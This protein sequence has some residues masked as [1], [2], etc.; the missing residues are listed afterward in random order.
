VLRPVSSVKV[1]FG[2]YRRGPPRSILRAMTNESAAPTM[3]LLT[4]EQVG[5]RLDLTP[6]SVDGLVKSGEL[7]PVRVSS[8]NDRRFWPDEIMAYALHA[9]MSEDGRQSA[10]QVVSEPDR[11][12]DT[13]VVNPTV[14]RPGRQPSWPPFTGPIEHRVPAYIAFAR[15]QDLV[16]YLRR[17]AEVDL[18]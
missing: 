11:A 14:S 18:D 15:R 7:S 13:T 1:T 16:N 17:R 9:A 6:A 2:P 3:A 8:G 12:R 10:L 5:L 4:R